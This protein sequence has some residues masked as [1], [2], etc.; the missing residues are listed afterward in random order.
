MSAEHDDQQ[1]R[2][3]LRVIESTLPRQPEATVQVTRQQIDEYSY[4]LLKEFI[5]PDIDRPVRDL[6]VN[7]LFAFS[8][9][10]S[11]HANPNKIPNN[12]T[13]TVRAITLQSLR[14]AAQDTLKL[15]F[16]QR[17][18]CKR[19]DNIEGMRLTFTEASKWRRIRM[20][21]ETAQ[22]LNPPAI[23]LTIQNHTASRPT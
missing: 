9:L 18:E 6:A 5:Y 21:L 16:E 14:E 12:E 8:A 11:H 20:V 23:T 19:S 7:F 2:P 17:R 1:R 4:D 10:K 3:N 15:T 22:T 13:L